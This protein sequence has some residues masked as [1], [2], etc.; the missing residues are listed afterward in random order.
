M[1]ARAK[2]EGVSFGGGLEGLG[3]PIDG[4]R[5][6]IDAGQTGKGLV[7]RSAGGWLVALP[8]PLCSGRI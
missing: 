4:V 2:D 6:E 3:I 5:G 1:V 8:S 7:G